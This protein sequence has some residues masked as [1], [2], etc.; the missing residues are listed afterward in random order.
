[1]PSTL[2][3]TVRFA[4]HCILLGNGA[5]NAPLHLLCGGAMTVCTP[6]LPRT[7]FT[8]TFYPAVVTLSSAGRGHERGR[9][10]AASK[11]EHKS[12]T[13]CCSA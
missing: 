2:L 1:M 13:G 11:G 9:R 6:C 12:F 4:V 7:T 5:N 3:D 8:L 10:R